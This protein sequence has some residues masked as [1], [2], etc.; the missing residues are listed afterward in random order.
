M[1]TK[2][3]IFPGLQTNDYEHKGEKELQSAL[4]SNIPEKFCPYCGAQYEDQ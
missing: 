3:R 2:K 1:E 4:N